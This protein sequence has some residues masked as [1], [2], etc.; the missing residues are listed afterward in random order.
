MKNMTI[1]ATFSLLLLANVQ[2]GT[3]F[4]SISTKILKSKESEVSF[5]N[6][7][8]SLPI[9]IARVSGGDEVGNGGDDL[10]LNFIKLSDQIIK[11]SPDIQSNDK[12]LKL[13]KKT[14]SISSIF[15]V[16]KLKLN[17]QSVPMTVIENSIL[18]DRQSWNSI[19]GLLSDNL[20]PRLEILRLLA[21]ASGVGFSEEDLL[22]IYSTLPFYVSPN[23]GA[24]KAVA[25][26][27][28][29]KSSSE[30]IEKTEKTFTK[31]S[32]N[33]AEEVIAMALKACLDDKNIH[34]CRILEVK[35]SGFVGFEKF[36]ATAQGFIYNK[37]SLSKADMKAER[38]LELQRCSSMYELAPTGQIESTSFS[39]LDNEI[40]SSCR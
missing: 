17:N 16:D 33:N 15:V 20:D 22:S 8:Q 36:K 38:C 11:D 28:A 13:L 12:A 14:I 7:K 19:D 6:N 2:A 39:E 35:Q 29:I 23:T 18:L 24:K 31:S 25:P 30:K 27:C 34:E 26:W 10:R 40:N 9:M 37:K 4:Q 3:N 5:N 32:A 1:F 21:A